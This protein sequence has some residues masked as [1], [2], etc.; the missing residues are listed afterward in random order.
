MM[1]SLSIKVNIAN[2][3]Y[4]MTIAWEDEEIVRNAAK[5]IDQKIKEFEQA[6]A[7]K[8]KQD[9]LSMCAL[10]FVVEKLKLEKKPIVEDES[11]VEKLEELEQFVSDYLRDK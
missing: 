11:V 1:S 8:D 9:V 5:L 10:Q 6:Y 2:R 3:V 4:P 7:V